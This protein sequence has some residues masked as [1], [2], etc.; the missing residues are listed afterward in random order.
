MALLLFEKTEGF[1][2]V[3][4]RR[5]GCDRSNVRCVHAMESVGPLARPDGDQSVQPVKCWCPPSPILSEGLR[6]GVLQP[7]LPDY[8]RPGFFDGSNLC[9]TCYAVLCR[10]MS[11]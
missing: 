2:E 5:H 6:A 8:F 1:R 11:T 4:F 10:V 9:Q 7:R 3:E